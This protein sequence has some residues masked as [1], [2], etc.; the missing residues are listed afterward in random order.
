MENISKS[1]Q[2][3]MEQKK[4]NEERK[5]ADRKAR[6]RTV[7]LSLAAGLAFAAFIGFAVYHKMTYIPDTVTPSQDFSAILKDDGYIRGVNASKYVKDFDPSVVEV[8]EEDIEYT[9]DD[10]ENDIEQILLQHR[11]LHEE[12][13]LAVK[14]GDTIN[15][16]YVGKVDGKEFIGGSTDGQG[17]DLVIG[18]GTFIDGFEEQLIGSHPGDDVTVKVTFPEEYASENLAGKD[19]EFAVHINGIYETFEFD[20]DFVKENF[21]EYD[22]ADAYKEY[23]IARAQKNT[24]GNAIHEWIMENY[25]LP[26][27]PSKYCHHMKELTET[28]NMQQFQQQMQMY[29]LY[30]MDVPYTDYKEYIEAMEGGVYEDILIEQAEHLTAANLLYQKICEDND[31]KISSDEYDTYIAENGITDEII[32]YYGKPYIKQMMLR[33]KALEIIGEG[34]TVIEAPQEAKDA[35]EEDSEEAVSE[36]ADSQEEIPAEEPE[37]EAETKND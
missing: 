25:W 32:D 20:D 33:E 18:S 35:M 1:K 19:A 4:W 17:A 31:I 26:M 11:V 36:E 14:D 10:L 2:K 12:K 9:E 30:G 7:S 15:L 8:Q 13:D 6:I 28:M 3:R 22:S 27:L 37:N 23:M 21:P 29:Q 16:D 24:K 5:A 34:V